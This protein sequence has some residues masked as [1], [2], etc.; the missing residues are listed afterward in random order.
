MRVFVTGATGYIGGSVA[1]ALAKQGAQ[2]TGLTR[3]EQGAQAL[4]DAGITPMVGR[5]DEGGILGS[6]VSAVDAVINAANADHARSAQALLAA[7]DGTGKKL[8]HTSGSS[9]VGTEAMG[10]VVDDVFDE[11]TPFTPTTLRAGRVALNLEILSSKVFKTHPVVI[12]PSMIY[13]AGHYGG[14]ESMQVPWLIELALSHG[15]AKH[16]GP[17]ANIWSTVHIDDVVDLFLKALESAPA[18]AFYWAEA[19]EIS[20]HEICVAINKMLG[21]DH[22]PLEMTLEEAAAVWGEMPARATMGSNS[23]VRAVRARDELGWVPSGPTISDEIETGHY[24][25]KWGTP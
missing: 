10:Q 18:G 25:R 1:V 7:L 17:G 13:G 5:L 6:A 20:M 22:P 4:E 23:R 24:A 19:A 9:I 3:T 16:L 8:I 14:R 2:V 15:V 11:E 12:A 21:V